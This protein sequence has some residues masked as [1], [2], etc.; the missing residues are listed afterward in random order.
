LAN[1]NKCNQNIA[2]IQE[3]VALRDEAARLLGY[4]DHATFALEDKM[5]KTPKTVNDFLDDL[6]KRLASGAQQELE[7]LKKLQRTDPDCDD[8]DHYYI[9]DH[10]YYSNLML[11]RDFQLEQNKIAEYFP[12][13]SCIAGMLNIFE[14]LFGLGFVEI[15][16]KDR[17]IISETGNGDDIVWHPDV[18]LFSVWDDAK[19]HNGPSFV[20]YLY[21]D[22]HPREGK[23]GHAANF[24]LQPGFA[25]KDGRQ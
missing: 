24:P 18:R 21:F 20:G 25:T 6:R 8:T 1:E 11:E 17:N 9:W 5:A 22:L 14:E 12:L 23:F 19:E 2:L 7:K 15:E 3:A 10:R 4:T 16:G 13:Q